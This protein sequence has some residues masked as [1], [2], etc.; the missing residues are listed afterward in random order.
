[1]QRAIAPGAMQAMERAFMQDTGYPSLLLMEHAAQAVA[2]ALAGHAEKEAK[3]IFVC[4]AGNNGGDG[5]AAA[6]LWRQMG[7]RAVCCAAAPVEALAGDARLNAQLCLRL[8]IEIVPGERGLPLAGASA[9]VDALFGT[10]LS[11]DV[12]GVFAA[13]IAQMNESG[14]PVVSVDIPSGVDGATGRVMGIAVHASETVTFHRPKPGHYL[15]PGRELT[16]RLTVAQIGIPQAFD[17]ADG[18]DVL[19]ADD[20]LLPVRAADAHKGTCGHL[21]VLAGSRGMAGAAVLCALG[22]LR[23]GAGL[24]TAACVRDVLPA[25]QTQAFCAMAAPVAEADGA[26]CAQGAPQIERLAQG[27][28]AAVVGPGLS[29][30]PE[31][32]QA[33]R[34]VVQSDMPKAVDADALNLLARAE[35]APGPRT[36][37]TPHPGEAARL[38]KT[39]VYAIAKDPVAAAV[40][41]RERLRAVVLLKGATTVIAGERG[42][43]LMPVGTCAMATGG[44]GDVLAG[45]CGA[46]LCQGIPPYEAARAAALWHARAGVR[47]ERALGTRQVTALDIA[48]HL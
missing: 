27:K 8:G 33:V 20:A 29:Q 44:S 13:L 41:L 4:G 48:A 5:Y 18:P 6:R 43:T 22:G 9:V 3:A 1:M 2:Q 38:L 17:S 7:G 31:V 19:E 21:L 42:V 32:W 46:L 47:A 23:G 40:A 16:G 30:R 35:A 45:L 10:G 12:E 39:D 36:V 37:L 34:G 28:Q 11:R 15:S 26:F 25:L 24:V 14:L